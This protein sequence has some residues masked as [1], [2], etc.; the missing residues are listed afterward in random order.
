MITSP[1]PVWKSATR[2]SSMPASTA[3]VRRSA[4]HPKS[5]PP[6]R[7][8]LPHNR[9]R[10]RRLPVPAENILQLLPDRSFRHAK[11]LPP[12]GRP[13]PTMRFGISAGAR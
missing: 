2:I 3:E 10:S 11:N 13:S 6:L 4:P 9:Q 7:Q 12:I 1:L 8:F 5:A